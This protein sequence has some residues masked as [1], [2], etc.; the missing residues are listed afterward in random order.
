MLSQKDRR[1]DLQASQ[2]IDTV[3][4]VFSILSTNLSKSQAVWVQTIVSLFQS[5]YKILIIQLKT[6]I[7]IIHPNY[8]K[9]I[10]NHFRLTR[11]IKLLHV[12]FFVSLKS[13]GCYI[14]TNSSFVT[15]IYTYRIA[16]TWA[17]SVITS[18]SCKYNV[19]RLQIMLLIIF[20]TQNAT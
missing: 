14:L 15:S 6:R 16:V 1:T 12:F 5:I 11:C 9:T 3:G 2:Q 4:S 19:H 20:I 13:L 18:P 7:K 17:S 10:Y 8:L